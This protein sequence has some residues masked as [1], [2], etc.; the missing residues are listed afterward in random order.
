V[1]QLIENFE[2][3]FLKTSRSDF[4]IGDT[5]KVY[6]RIVVV[7]E[8]DENGK[9]KKASK[10]EAKERVQVFTGTVM[11]KKGSGLSETFTLYRNAYGSSMEKVFLLNSPKISKIEIVRAGRVRRAKLTYI[12]GRT[13]KAAKIREKMRLFHH[14]TPESK[15]TESAQAEIVIKSPI[16]EPE[17]K[18]P[19]KEEPPKQ[20]E[21]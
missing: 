15:K 14:E 10:K 13:G 4:K 18:I 16:K 11:A 12:R 6:L 8:A 9:K 7:E 21:K 1:N 5:I 17:A 19:P 20:S 2:K 3:T